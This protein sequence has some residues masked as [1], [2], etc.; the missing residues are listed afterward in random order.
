MKVKQ[1][2]LRFPETLI[3]RLKSTADQQNVSVNNLVE[4]YRVNS[5]DNESRDQAEYSRMIAD[6]FVPLS[7]IYHLLSDNISDSEF[8]YDITPLS[9]AEI[10]FAGRRYSDRNKQAQRQ[11]ALV[12]RRQNDCR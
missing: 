12:H 9:P 3:D 8:N 10:R 4:R 1:L 6:P 2:N 11:I 7:R 5:L